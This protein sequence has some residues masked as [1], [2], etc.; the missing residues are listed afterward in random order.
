V[1]LALTAKPQHESPSLTSRVSA[2]CLAAGAQPAA[3]TATAV[4]VATASTSAAVVAV[5]AVYAP[6]QVSLS[7]AASTAQILAGPSAG[8]AVGAATLDIAVSAKNL[9]SWPP[10]ADLR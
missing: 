2:R 9:G 3:S 7:A 8:V 5:Q 1:H 10:F 4:V 6:A